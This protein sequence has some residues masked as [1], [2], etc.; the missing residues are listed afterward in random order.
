MKRFIL[1]VLSLFFSLLPFQALAYA[2]DS[3]TAQ[4]VKAVNFRT[5]PATSAHI[6]RLLKAGEQ[7]DVLAKVNNYWIKAKD[8]SG[9]IGYVSSSDTYIRL[10]NSTTPAQTNA[11]LAESNATVVK[12]VS[13]RKGPSVR[14]ARIRYL[15][16]GERLL[17][18]D[19]PNAYWYKAK[20][21]NGVIGYVSTSGNYIQTTYAPPAPPVAIPPAPPANS[22]SEAQ[23]VIAAGMKYLGTPYEFG[24]SR[25][26]TSTFD[27]SDFVRQAFLDGIGLKLPTDSRQQGDYVK[28]VGKITA[29]WR[30]LKPGDLMFF[31]S[32]K[33]YKASDYDGINKMAQRITHVALYIGDG[34][35]LHTY[36]KTS[37]GVRTDTIDGKSWEYRF[38]FGGPAF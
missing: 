18:L 11:Q 13:F 12:S 36:S 34:K 27:C 7:L 35:I 6:I 38:M 29:D 24:S 5:D 23:K 15:Q 19:K 31:M 3:Q 25:S 4:V 9:R 28:G 30:Q 1:L 8:S 37:G 22:S 10:I 16:A 20:D 14:D 26:N 21:K 33:G 17:I 2:A 32:Y